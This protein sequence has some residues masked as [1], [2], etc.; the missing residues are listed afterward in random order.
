MHI[1]NASNIRNFSDL[2]GLK[3][4]LINR[5]SRLLEE[6][7]AQINNCYLFEDM[8]EN[9]EYPLF[10]QDSQNEDEETAIR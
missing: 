4:Y 10:A 9:G 6:T 7:N 3:Q 8:N 2:K 5:R 1:L